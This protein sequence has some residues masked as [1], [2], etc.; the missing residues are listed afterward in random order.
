ME[1]H[2]QW[3][4]ERCSDL[5][6]NRASYMNVRFLLG[7]KSDKLTVEGINQRFLGRYNIIEHEQFRMRLN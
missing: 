4:N 2:T 5:E 6:F 1:Q 3:R 7:E